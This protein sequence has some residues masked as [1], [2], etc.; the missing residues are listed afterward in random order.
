VGRRGERVRK[1][2]ERERGEWKKDQCENGT[3]SNLQRM[4]WSYSLV[5]EGMWHHTGSNNTAM[6][7]RN[8]MSTRT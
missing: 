2:C 3:I 8:G 5:L 4:L 1:G 6:G 7:V